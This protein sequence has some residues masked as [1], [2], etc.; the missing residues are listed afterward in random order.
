M[1]QIWAL[2]FMLFAVLPATTNYELKSYGFGSGSASNS[3]TSNYAI[4]GST[5]NFSGQSLSTV[6]ATAQPGQTPTQQANVPL[7]TVDNGS[8]VYYNKL[9]FVLNQQSNP[10]DATYL[11]SVSTD[12][13]ASNVTYV[14][15][16]GTLSSTL[17]T[18]DYQTYATWGSASGSYIIGLTPSTTYYVRARATQGKFS[19]SAWSPSVTQATAPAT[20]TFNLTTSTQSTGPFSVALGSLIP[21]TVTSSSSTINT[22]LSTNG[23]SG[24]SVYVK[25]QNGGLLSSSNSHLISSTS[26]DL[27]TA[28]DGFGG[29]STSVTQTSGGPYTAV[30]P[31]NG[32]GSV[33]GSIISNAQSLYDSTNPVTSGTGTF[34]LKAKAA[35]TDVA[36][37]D[38]QDVLTFIAAGNF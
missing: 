15:P 11:I 26:T 33:V 17:L 5:G 12:N 21:G 36:A 23:A 16:D 25:S 7:I 29:Q 37:S 35:S 27:S 4:N 9:H 34:T 30:T 6:N 8:S 2:G 10:T 22:I 31:Y 13:F 24:G 3:T 32:T 19:E 14:Q 18:S 28:S 20:I 38:Y 1:K